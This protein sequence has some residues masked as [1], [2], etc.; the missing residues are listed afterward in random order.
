[1]MA[2]VI[3]IIKN[4]PIIININYIN[5]NL[6]VINNYFIFKCLIIYYKNIKKNPKLLLLNYLDI[7]K[8]II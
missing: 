8:K 4:L 2:A 5:Y 3:N 7:S 6:I 1:M